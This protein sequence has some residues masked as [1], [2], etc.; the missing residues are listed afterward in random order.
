[1]RDEGDWRCPNARRAE[2]G[3]RGR[4][5]ASC[6]GGVGG[7]MVTSTATPAASSSVSAPHNCSAA[8]AS[9]GLPDCSRSIVAGAT[10]SER[11]GVQAMLGLH[12][13]HAEQASEEQQ[14][15]DDG[16]DKVDGTGSVGC[17][18]AP[19]RC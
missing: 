18:P 14:E 4:G 1:M 10:D 3:G 16:D 2:A 13:A 15:D 9:R 17:L 6:W 11:L 12:S 19:R 8:G 5:G 7:A